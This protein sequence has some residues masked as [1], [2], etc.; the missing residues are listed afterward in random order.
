[1]A[2]VAD[3]LRTNL[4]PDIGPSRDGTDL[5]EICR[6][7][8]AGLI[9]TKTTAGGLGGRNLPALLDRPESR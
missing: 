1:M 3:G 7:S 4:R 8:Q 2:K 5:P 9:D 6:V